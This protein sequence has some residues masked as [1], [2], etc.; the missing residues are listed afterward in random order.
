[1]SSARE[2]GIKV[3][4]NYITIRWDDPV[5]RDHILD[6]DSHTLA[7]TV[8]FKA[9]SKLYYVTGCNSRTGEK[10]IYIGKAG[11]TSVYERIKDHREK[12]D[13]LNGCKDLQVRIGTIT[14]T[15]DLDVSPRDKDLV[16]QAESILIH[17]F[18]NFNPDLGNK[19]IDNSAKKD[20][21]TKYYDIDGI[22]NIGNIDDMPKKLNTEYHNT[23]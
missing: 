23:I 12:H 10:R 18:K 20:S 6:T 22:F 1:M 21:Y 11:D 7:E 9:K 14:N 19:M 13:M 2:K 17:E 16:D 5:S 3:M 8:K 4:S 15:G